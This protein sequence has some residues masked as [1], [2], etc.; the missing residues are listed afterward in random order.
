MKTVAWVRE[1]ARP[2]PTLALCPPSLE[3]KN[4]PQTLGNVLSIFWASKLDSR[5][6]SGDLNAYHHTRSERQGLELMLWRP[7]PISSHITEWQRE[8]TDAILLTQCLGLFLSPPISDIVSVLR[9]SHFPSR[10]GYNPVNVL[11]LPGN[12]FVLN[13]DVPKATILV[14]FLGWYQFWALMLYLQRKREWKINRGRGI[15]VFVSW[16]SF[17]STVHFFQRW[18]WSEK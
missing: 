9:G 4:N 16:A 11:C 15:R 14:Y 13:K 17:V 7:L 1:T 8:E 5:K 6:R 10:D 2:E 12:R 3:S 18:S